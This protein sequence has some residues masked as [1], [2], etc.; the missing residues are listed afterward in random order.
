MVAL[1]GSYQ[2]FRSDR[3]LGSA[4]SSRT[5]VCVLKILLWALLAFLLLVVVL[6]L[7]GNVGAWELLLAAVLV[8]VPTFF[9]LGRR[10]QAP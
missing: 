5:G 1:T 3:K 7:L 10:R 4:P 8:A 2:T 9:A 6:G